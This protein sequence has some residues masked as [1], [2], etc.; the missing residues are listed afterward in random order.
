MLQ[1][2]LLATALVLQPTLLRRGARPAQ[3]ATRSALEHVRAQSLFASD[4][5]DEIDWDKEAAALAKPANRFY[6]AIKE[7][8]APDM[9]KQFAESAPQEVQTAV[10]VTI[11]QLLGNLPPQVAESAIEAKGQ[12]LASL[13]FSMQASAAACFDRVTPRL[14]LS[15]R[16]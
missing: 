13:M 7:I 8:E 3:V 9:V 5:D 16:D 2:L 12:S 10:K 1:S 6:K 15:R 4:G 11:S 14:H